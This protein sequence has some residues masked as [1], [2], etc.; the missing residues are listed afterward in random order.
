MMKLIKSRFA[1]FWNKYKHG[2]VLLYL[3]IYMPWFLYLEKVNTQDVYII[4]SWI[5]DK[6]PFIEYFIVP[7]LLWFIYIFTTILYLFFTNKVDFYKFCKF[8]IIG[9]TF[10]L[11]LSTLWP[12]GVNLRPTDL[13]ND[14]IFT[15]LTLQLYASDTSTNVFPSLHVFNSLAACIAIFHNK[16]L[17]RYKSLQWGS[18]LLTLLIILSTMFLKQHSIYDVLGGCA[19]AY[20]LYIFVY[21]PKAK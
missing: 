6:I 20:L 18:F 5:D 9:M 21:K 19:M 3:G 14:N 10:F 15:D 12:N 1:Q 11:I 7:Y 16:I 13:I 17:Q 4:H 2:W 8:S